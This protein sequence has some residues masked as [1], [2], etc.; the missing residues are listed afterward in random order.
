MLQ[1]HSGGKN[2][3]REIMQLF[4]IGL[5]EL[6]EDG[7]R[8]LD[9]HG[10][11]I[12]TYSND[13]LLEYARVW[14][15][16]RENVGRGNKDD[17][18][19]NRI[20]PMKIE[21]KWRDVFPKMGLGQQYIGDGYPL[22]ADRPD[23][24]FLKRGAKYILLGENPL[25]ELQR[26]NKA[27][28][29]HSA[30]AVR[31][32][33]DPMGDLNKALCG[34]TGE[35]NSPCMYPPVVTLTENLMCAGNECSL[36]TVRVVEVTGGVFYEYVPLPCVHQAFFENAQKIKKKSLD[37]GAAWMCADPRIP[38][39]STACCFK[40]GSFFAYESYWGEMTKA[41]TAQAKCVQ[42]A[43]SQRGEGGLHL[44]MCTSTGPFHHKN[45][46]ETAGLY[47][48]GDYFYWMSKEAPCRI[49]AKIDGERIALV[50]SVPDEAASEKR[51]FVNPE[52]DQKTFFRAQFLSNGDKMAELGRTC[53][54]N[55]EC[56]IAVD[57]YCMCNVVV[58]NEQAYFA[59]PTRE[60]V[61]SSLTIGSFH[62]DVL[63]GPFTMT[64]E[65]SVNV[66]ADEPTHGRY[67][68]QTVFEV[69]D[70]F[71]VIQLRRNVRSVVR[72]G[73]TNITFRNPVHFMSFVEPTVRDAQYETDAALDHYLYHKNTAPFL[74]IR[75][76][77]RFGI[78]N[79]SPGYIRV[80][81]DA[82]RKGIYSH[83]DGRTEGYFGQG[84]H[85]DLEATVAAI[86]LDRE[87]RSVVLDADPVHGAMKEPILKITALMRN[88]EFTST[89]EFPFPRFSK[90]LQQ[91]L[92]QMIYQAPSI[93]SFFHPE[94]Q[95][96]GVAISAGLVSPEAE[97]HSAPQII[98]T[99][100]G[101]L[102]MIKYGLDRCFGGLGHSLNWD[103]T[104]E[105]RSRIPGEYV[106]ASSYP[107]FV[108]V[109]A[110]SA[111]RIVDE[112]ALVMTSG[113]LSTEHRDTILEVIN[114]EPEP[115]QAILKA[116]QLIASSSEFHSTG[117]ITNRGRGRRREHKIVPTE[118]PYKALV[119]LML[120]GGCD[121][122]NLV[123]PHTCSA[124]NDAGATVMEQYISERGEIG[125][126][127]SER[128]LSIAVEGQPCEKFAIHKDIPVLKEL[129]EHG[130]LSFFF[131]AGLINKPST[132]K[133]YEAMT[134]S[135]HFAH[136]A[137]QAEVQRIDP[138]N[139]ISRT[140]F[141]HRVSETLNSEA[142][143][144]QAQT[145]SI[146]SLNR[147]VQ[148]D[149]AT[150]P[151]RPLVVGESGPQTFN[152]RPATEQFD[153]RQ[154]I[155]ELNGAN[156]ISSNIFGDYWSDSFMRAL[157]ESDFL[158][159]LLDNVSLNS[160]DGSSALE[161]I[162]KLMETR[163]GRGKDRDLFFTMT[164]GWDHHANQKDQLAVKFAELNEALFDFRRNLKGLDLWE[165]VTLLVVS[166]FGRTV[167][168]NTNRGSDRTFL[169]V[170]SGWLLVYSIK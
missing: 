157:D 105:C 148:G 101:L 129:Y 36:D 152:E 71:G 26:D 114:S 50:H 118:S 51:E 109:D 67:S 155:E 93:F 73:G 164:S 131:N 128:N 14:T 33:A 43:K 86:L 158:T 63:D 72:I 69:V 106:N 117:T 41:S 119:V 21:E 20:D 149:D 35:P 77:Q 34:F 130:E 23:H 17:T 18:S 19:R 151:S 3:A 140:G 161:M 135:H 6:H 137:M 124:T 102:T 87:A 122:Y 99:M 4:T 88:L 39:A 153:P 163:D 42:Q 150:S 169:S 22:C 10:R 139:E 91:T 156:H 82:F 138:Y 127:H 56:S 120:V 110:N 45:C 47:C 83:A 98:G 100:N 160:T 65:G 8:K 46:S 121:S 165:N 24:H 113:R 90:D 75:L 53:T 64:T 94:F 145:I 96:T 44:T 85:G 95:P 15:G 166:E 70:D 103:G 92:G 125:L 147:A 84:L 126:N 133:T 49:K 132:K 12:R 61:L 48:A 108:P 5:Y 55:P 104:G 58:T 13:D 54:A 167:T 79:P 1:R 134:V 123:V 59:A 89:P 170:Y 74:A 62:P 159:D 78:S 146:N 25:P 32:V 29:L 116:E 57:G 111:V 97:V 52:E 144:F 38:A 142:Y 40:G 115:M 80:I 76:A 136:D 107:E 9:E 27:W 141:L 28:A 162:V 2:Y 66:H 81:A 143:G 16:F 37:A 112:L 60:E 31:F 154:K 168:P 30:G 11:P 68:N 7:T